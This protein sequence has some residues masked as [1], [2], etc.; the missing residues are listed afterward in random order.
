MSRSSSRPHRR[1]RWPLPPQMRDREVR[2]GA[3]LTAQDLQPCKVYLISYEHVGVMDAADR[4]QG[5]RTD[6]DAARDVGA[7]GIAD[8]QQATGRDAALL[9]DAAVDRGIGLAEP[10]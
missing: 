5:R 3:E 2:R 7:Q 6:S 4:E 9:E 8:A 1:D 10:H